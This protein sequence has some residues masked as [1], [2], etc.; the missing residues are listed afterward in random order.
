MLL[1]TI[2]KDI[3]IEIY[4]DYRKPKMTLTCKTKIGRR[5]VKHEAKDVK[6][7]QL[8]KQKHSETPF[9]K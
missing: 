3:K 1:H 4:K 7:Y 8:I 2:H 9:S 5:K 6:I